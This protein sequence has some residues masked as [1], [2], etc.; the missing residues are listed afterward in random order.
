MAVALGQ[1]YRPAGSAAGT[2]YTLV[3]ETAPTPAT[4]YEWL[5][6]RPTEHGLHAPLFVSRAHLGG[7][8]DKT[9]VMA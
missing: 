5:I 4:N 9:G 1:A 7:R 6:Q 3:A 2:R 8:P